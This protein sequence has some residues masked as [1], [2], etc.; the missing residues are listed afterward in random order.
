MASKS[1]E[2]EDQ[3][4]WSNVHVFNFPWERMVEAAYRKYPNPYSSS[5]HSL[6]TLERSVTAAPGEA[7]GT[8]ILSRRLFCTRWNIPSFITRMTGTDPEVTVSE[9]SVC[10]VG[11]QTLT[12]RARNISKQNFFTMDET[13]VYSVCPEDRNKT[14]L[15]QSANVN[16]TIPVIGGLLESIWLSQYK[17]TVDNGR[18]GI[19]SVAE[20][21]TEEIL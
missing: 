4:E 9:Q 11:R 18:K 19:V 21:I 17:S 1:D 7:V 14:V 12:I 13:L 15:K 5:V 16:I 8:R 20:K 6:D 2:Q 10:D 3:T